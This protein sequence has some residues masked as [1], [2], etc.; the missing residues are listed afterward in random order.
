MSSA[1]FPEFPVEKIVGHRFR[2]GVH[3]FKVKWEGYPEPS[4]EPE[5]SFSNAWALV[6]EFLEQ[7]K[8]LRE[9]APDY[10]AERSRLFPASIHRAQHRIDQIDNDSVQAV[11]DVVL[12]HGK[13]QFG[14]LM[15][16]GK[17]KVATKDELRKANPQELIV[18]LEKLVA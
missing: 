9:H 2:K 12:A 17:Q 5:S 11:L 8:L 3:Y 16:S 4:W 15:T 1:E 18:F 10:S 7:R 13:C 14:V 6:D